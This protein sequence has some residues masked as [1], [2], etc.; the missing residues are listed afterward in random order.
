MEEPIEK[1]PRWGSTTKLLVGLVIIGFIAFLI[2]RFASLI[3]PL[4]MI[5]IFAYLFHPIGGTDRQCTAHLM[6][7]CG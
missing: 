2:Y 5:F 7:G 4:L 1:S 6:E 3:S